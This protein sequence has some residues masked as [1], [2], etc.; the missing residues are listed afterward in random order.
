MAVNGVELGGCGA[1]RGLQVVAWF[2]HASSKS[3]LGVTGAAIGTTILGPAR[4]RTIRGRGGGA[5]CG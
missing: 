3:F 5:V 1:Q 4:A 2:A